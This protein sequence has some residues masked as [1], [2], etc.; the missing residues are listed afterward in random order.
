MKLETERERFV[1]MD[2]LTVGLGTSRVSICRATKKPLP[3]FPRLRRM[4]GKAGMLESELQQF[5]ASLP[6][7]EAR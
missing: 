6:V 1:P 2:E 3:G 5:L 7:V 4:N